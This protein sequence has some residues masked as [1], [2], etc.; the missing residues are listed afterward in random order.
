MRARWRESPSIKTW[1]YTRL[2]H[3]NHPARFMV[4]GDC[5]R[6]FVCSLDRLFDGKRG[7][8]DISN[9]RGSRLARHSDRLLP[10]RQM[11]ERPSRLRI[12]AGCLGFWTKY[13]RPAVLSFDFHR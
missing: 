1:G 7:D 5:D 4:A 11:Q 3:D 12:L 10:P 2:P 9:A 13:L 6:S 8:R